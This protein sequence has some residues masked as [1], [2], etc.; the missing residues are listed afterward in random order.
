MNGLDYSQGVPDIT[1]MKQ[2]NV[3]FVC[4]YV[5]WSDLAQTKILTLQEAKTLSQNGIAIVS[6][7]EWYNTRPQ[8][9]SQA[10]DVDVARALQIHHACGGPDTAPIYFSVDYDSPGSD[11]VAYFK[12]LAI[13]LGI[14]RVGAY[15]GY[16][17]IKYLF[18]N[19]LITWG[20][21]TYA[22]SNNQ[23]DSRAHI[24][25]TQNNVQFGGVAVDFDTG[26]FNNVGQWKI[27]ETP[28]MKT[29]SDGTIATAPFWYQLSENE[30]N[31]CGPTTVSMAIHSVA[32]GAQ[33]TATPETI[34]Q[35]TD[36]IIKDVFNVADPTQF[37]GVGGWNTD[38]YDIL[39]YLQGKYPNTFHFYIVA[40]IEQLEAAVHSGYPCIFGCNEAD[41][42]AWNKSKNAWEHA[43]P[44]QLS[45]GHI[46]GVFVGIEQNTGNWLVT[47][48]LNNRFQGYGPPY[49]YRRSDIAKSFT[50]GTIIQ[51]TDW[52]KS[53]PD[54]NNWPVNF[55]AQNFSGGN[56]HMQQ[57]FDDVWFSD[58][59]IVPAG[60]KSG[61][62]NDTLNGYLA[63]KISAC[64][65][66]QAEI[67][68][69]DW[70][71]IAIKMQPL[72]NGL[73][74]AFNAGIT[75]YYDHTNT[76]VYQSA[77]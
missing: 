67:D 31:T 1:A 26:M 9:G 37:Q 16:A 58:P 57:Q 2:G 19:H 34:D 74:A 49:I 8:E 42:T 45:A 65:P 56:S 59:T 29:N 53:I 11:V 66:L 47:D 15:G 21:Q 41:I 25:Q 24:R 39:K 27:G 33:L 44:W 12:E 61:I 13:K 76:L 14:Q 77:N 72:S 64:R 20:W 68:T 32:P 54:I 10:A 75:Y 50:G 73:I 48:P 40:T 6:N 23:W 36:A 52:L 55:N 46:P 7:Y 22:W 4:R 28:N 18:D 70:S 35:D 30:M 71:G 3:A 60:Y 43:Y 62:Y 69:V 17:C 51:L 38:M 5:G 63:R